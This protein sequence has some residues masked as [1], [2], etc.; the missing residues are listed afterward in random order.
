MRDAVAYQI[1]VGTSGNTV[2]DSFDRAMRHVAYIAEP[3]DAK[4]ARLTLLD[5]YPELA[6]GELSGSFFQRIRYA[7]NQGRLESLCIVE[8][9]LNA[10]PG[11]DSDLFWFDIINDFDPGY[12]VQRA[13]YLAAR[14]DE[15][16]SRIADNLREIVADGVRFERGKFGDDAALARL[17]KIERLMNGNPV[18]PEGENATAILNDLPETILSRFQTL[19]QK[20]F[21]SESL[22]LR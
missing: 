10:L 12:E 17:R 5:E 13:L 3:D 4:R 8:H 7:A 18:I 6:S 2:L 22:I 9:D 15:P 20:A 14:N 19:A 21:P 11:S 16:L 1:Q